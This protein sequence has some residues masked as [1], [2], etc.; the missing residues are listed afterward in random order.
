MLSTLCNA[1]VMA[2]ARKWQ[3]ALTLRGAR[4]SLGSQVP[5]AACAGTAQRNHNF[6]PNLQGSAAAR[7]SAQLQ[8]PLSVLPGHTQP[9]GAQNIFL[10][11]HLPGDLPAEYRAPAGG[12][13]GSAGFSNT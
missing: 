4:E 1:L 9:P 2:G 8:H 12:M 7:S 3:V 6:S 10:A 11:P 13:W 5:G